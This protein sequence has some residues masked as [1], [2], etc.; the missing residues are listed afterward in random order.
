MWRPL[1]QVMARLACDC[2]R[3]VREI[4]LAQLQRSFLNMANL[5]AAEWESCFNDVRFK[6]EKP[7]VFIL[8]KFIRII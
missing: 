3:R 8:L 4:A 1:L 6:L 2:R 7:N 5:G